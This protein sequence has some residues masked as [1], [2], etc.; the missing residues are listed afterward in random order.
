MYDYCGGSHDSYGVSSHSYV[1]VFV[2]L[3]MEIELAVHK[4]SSGDSSGS[5]HGS[6][7]SNKSSHN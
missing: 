1:L 3:V 2:V 4:G 5:S 7:S 6:G